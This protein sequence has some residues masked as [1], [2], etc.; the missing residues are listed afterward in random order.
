MSVPHEG[1]R[2]ETGRPEGTPLT[3]AL[4]TAVV[5]IVREYTGRGP[6][7]AR[8]SIRDNVVLVMLEDTLTKGELAL[9][10]NGRAE[11]VIDIRSEFQAAMRA[12]CIAKVSELT[13]RRVVAMMSANHISPDLGAELFVL[14]AAPDPGV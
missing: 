3:A 14:D 7:R 1:Q 6:T 2:T 8:T 9:V 13:G 12:D 11:K 5:G 10:A 4:S